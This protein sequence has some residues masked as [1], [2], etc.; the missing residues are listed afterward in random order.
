MDK[1]LEKVF[2]PQGAFAKG[3]ANYEFREGQLA[4]AG[5]I[6]DTLARGGHLVVEAGTG[7]G[8]S[9]AY[10]VPFIEWSVG[11]GK[12]VVVSTYTKALQEQLAK[13]DMPFLRNA[14][15]VDFSFALCFGGENYLCKRRLNRAFQQGLF[16]TKR[17]ASE[18]EAI[19]KWADETQAGVRMELPFEP[20]DSIWFRVCRETDLCRG[21]KCSLRGE[22]F[23][24]RA[25]AEQG[26]AHVLI[27]NHHLFFADIAS[28]RQILPSYDGVIFDEAHDL[29]DVAAE[30]F[31]FDLTNT[32]LKYLLDEFHHPKQ[33]TGFF[34]RLKGLKD[35]GELLVLVNAAR[36]AGELFFE[37]VLGSIEGRPTLTIREPRSFENNLSAPLTELAEAISDRID[38]IEDEE[39][40]GELEA[41]TSRLT[42]WAG[43]LGEFVEQK[44]EGHVYWIEAEASPRRTKCHLCTS[45]VDVAPFMKRF[46]FD[47]ISPIVM[48]SATMAVGESF[49]FVSGRL[50]LKGQREVLIESPFDFGRQALLYA[51][52]DLPDPAREGERHID[53]I[54]ARIEDLVNI[55]S[56]SSF[57]LF[58]SYQTLG[59]VH[60]ALAHKLRD[61][62]VLRQGE[63]P[64]WMLLDEFKKGGAV[65]FGTTTF[66]QGID[67]P[68]SALEC[69]IITRL[70]FAVPDHPLVEARI[71]DLEEKGRNAFMEYQVPKA[72]LLFKQGFGRLIRHRKDVGI[73][74]ILDPRIKT[75]HY[76]RVFLNSLPP[77]REVA[78]LHTVALEYEKLKNDVR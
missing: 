35:R 52:F 10:L 67:V 39:E 54:S 61:Y 37:S 33:R 57:V 8:K 40:Q 14:L 46:V 48:T 63:M 21:K 66:W 47:K 32:Q 55:T 71:K 64:R 42:G 59:R 34:S 3:L 31:G 77:C 22:C 69:V 53:A 5:A 25:R 15:N 26:K 51:P 65:L 11:E 12:R 27:A 7:I 49:E 45:P 78:D 19:M 1:K 44:R 6:A 50:G 58:T 70:P 74:A 72:A 17:D 29:E 13:K 62:N 18:L 20:A 41:Q 60:D 28:G 73:V 23:Y 30:H 9:F 4:M 56:G 2:G 16:E 68:G 24:A 75:R 76:G 38:D 36:Q 43:L